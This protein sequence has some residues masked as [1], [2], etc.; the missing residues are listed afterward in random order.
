MKMRRDVETLRILSAFGIVWFHSGAPGGEFAYS[1]LVVFLVLS[2]FLSRKSYQDTS[3]NLKM[4]AR[5]LLVPWSI[6]FLFYGLI[7]IFSQKP[8]VPLDNGVI[9]GILSGP[10]SHLW[11]L[12]FIFVLLVII[13]SAR[14]KWS[15]SSLA[16]TGYVFATVALLSWG[17]G[18]VPSSP[19]GY[20]WTQYGHAMTGISIGIFMMNYKALPQWLA[21][22]LTV[23]L[24]IASASAISIKGYGIPYTVGIS[25]SALFLLSRERE[26]KFNVHPLSRCTLGIYLIHP[27][28]LMMLGKYTL[29]TPTAKALLAFGGSTLLIWLFK[30]YF[31]DLSSYAA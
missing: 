9:A 31:P 25:L 18:S 11:Y 13:D 15:P 23:T 16:W 7:R 3:R 28:I 21:P 10:S 8:I 6:W 17:R 4:R 26:I 1:G 5:R 29:A 19:S 27:L 22:Y 30:K 12:P 14:M 20:P 2:V 24:L